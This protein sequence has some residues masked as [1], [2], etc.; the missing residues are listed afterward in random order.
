VTKGLVAEE[1]LRRHFL[2]AGYFVVR[3]VPV[4]IADVVITDLD[5]WLYQRSSVISRERA[6]VD[7]KNK[8]SP[9]VLERIVWARGLQEVLGLERCMVV[10]TDKRP[11]SREFGQG[12]GVLVFDGNFLSQAMS[13][14]SEQADRISEEEFLQKLRSNSVLD[15]SIDFQDYYARQKKLVIAALNFNGTNKLLD[16]IGFLF[17]EYLASGKRSETSI[18]L[19]YFVTSLCLI[20]IDYSVHHLSFDDA[21]VREDAL[22][23]GLRYGAAGKR[24][25]NEVLKTA[26]TLVASRPNKGL[27]EDETAVAKELS[28][29]LG[30][31]PSQGIAE[32]LSRPDVGRRLFSNAKVFE[33]AAFALDVP[34][35]N[36]LPSEAKGLLGLLVDFHA[37]D[38]K[39]IL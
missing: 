3:S 12:S 33:S 36:V 29:Q 18:R 20:T 24:R 27:F 31:I 26:L 6:N 19:L 23:E 10:S 34:Y 7:V 38:R 16:E 1:A 4:Q 9:Q 37:L 13:H 2:S 22:N 14:Y 15:R 28:D 25:A 17:R 8:K 5:L 35:P 21:R 32:Y 39:D 30:S 11:E